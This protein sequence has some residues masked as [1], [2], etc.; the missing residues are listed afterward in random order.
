MLIFLVKNRHTCTASLELSRQAQEG[1][2]VRTQMFGNERQRVWR[3]A[4][5]KSFLLKYM[6]LSACWDHV[7]VHMSVVLTRTQMQSSGK[8]V[9]HSWVVI[10]IGYL[11]SVFCAPCVLPAPLCRMSRCE[12]ASIEWNLPLWIDRVTSNSRENFNQIFRLSRWFL[13]IFMCENVT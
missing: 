1:L 3:A 5:W 8:R 9:H 13:W 2:P 12:N 7:H 10:K 4:A 6:L 11:Y